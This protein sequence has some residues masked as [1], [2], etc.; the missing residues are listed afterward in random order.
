MGLVSTIGRMAFTV[1]GLIVIL[2]AVMVGVVGIA[3]V[4]IMADGVAEDI[5]EAVTGAVVA[6]GVAGNFNPAD[7]RNIASL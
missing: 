6:V 5:A 2:G 4:A 3:G 1:I 7:N